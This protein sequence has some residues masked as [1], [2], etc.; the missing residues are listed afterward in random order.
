MLDG[1]MICYGSGMNSGT[2]TGD[3]SPRNLPLLVAGGSR[4]G[5]RHGQHI[6]HNQEKHPPLT[7]VLLTMM[8][9]M[10]VTNTAGFSD[11]SGVISELT[12]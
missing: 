9:K 1:T 7:N 3:H 6:A 8:Q 12:S 4:L 2:G 11:A 10:G 5:L